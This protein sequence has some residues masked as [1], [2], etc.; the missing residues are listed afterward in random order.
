MSV[1]GREAAEHVEDLGGL[2]HWLP[3]VA[4]GIRE[5]L[6]FAGVSSDVHVPL[7]QV[8]KLRF[9]VD[10]TMELIVAE[11][12]MD[13]APN[14]V[15][16][17]LGGAHDGTN[18]F[19]HGVI[20]PAED[21]VV[22]HG[23]IGITTI[24]RGWRG[25]EVG[26]ESKLADDSVKEFTPFGIV[27]LEEIKLDWNMMADVHSLENSGGRGLDNG[28]VDGST[29]V[30]GLGRG[31]VTREIS[32]DQGVEITIHG[33]VRGLGSGKKVASA[34]RNAGTAVSGRITGGKN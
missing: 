25:G 28:I 33:G 22:S 15:G 31:V 26:F 13:N 27:G 10:G 30:G 7:N 32:V 9:K 11:L 4:Q 16:R 6:E 29:I 17:G 5:T 18:V 20:E 1:F 24:V 12:S 14:L 3:N 19:R 34:A 2:T 23:P 21:A 8:A